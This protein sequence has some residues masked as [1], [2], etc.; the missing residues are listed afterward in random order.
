MV[1]PGKCD[2]I[3]WGTT[4]L[5]SGSGEIL[6]VIRKVNDVTQMLIENRNDVVT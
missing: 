3:P 2:G 1:F 4:G 5:L 6:A